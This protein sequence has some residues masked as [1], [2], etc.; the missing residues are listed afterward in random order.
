MPAFFFFF[1]MASEGR[2]FVKCSIGQEPLHTQGDFYYP[3]AYKANPLPT[4]SSLAAI[5]I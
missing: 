2:N 5:S 1:C 4:E 3:G